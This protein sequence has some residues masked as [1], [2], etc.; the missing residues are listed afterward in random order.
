MAARP[1]SSPQETETSAADVTG[2][3]LI[4]TTNFDR[5]IETA[6]DNAGVRPVVLSMPDHVQGSPPLIH[7]RCCVVKLHGD[8]LDTRIKNTRAEL[9]S[10]SGEFDGLLDRIFDE[11]GLVVCGWSAAWDRALREALSRAP[12]RRFT[13]YWAA[14]GELNDEAR[15]L[16]DRRRA[17]VIPINDAD[18]FFR[19]VQN[20]SSPFR[21]SRGRIRSPP[22]PPSRA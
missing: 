14:R 5:L 6:L 18:E 9:D 12:S 17:E 22:K 16:V 7:T 8:Y 3:H 21:N 13:T 2:R 20:T 10:Y 11:F 4:L 19:T 15:R 1:S